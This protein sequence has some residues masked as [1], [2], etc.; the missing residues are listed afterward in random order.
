MLKINV[1]TDFREVDKLLGDLR[2]QV[3]FIASKA[4]NDTAFSVRAR[5][6][7]EL[8]ARLDKPTR[9]TLGLPRV[10][11]ATKQ[12][13]QAEVFVNDKPIGGVAPIDLLA[14]QFTGGQR[15]AKRFELLL[16]QAGYLAGN[17]VTV[18]GRGMIIDAN[19]NP[20]RSQL[21]SIL[22]ALKLAS[23]GK[24]TRKS[25]TLAGTI[26]WSQ[27]RGLPRGAWLRKGRNEIV[28]L[29]LVVK[30]ATYQQRIDFEKT[31]K[32]EIEKTWSKHFE[33]AMSYAIKTSR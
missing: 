11:K 33:S 15:R 26:I 23:P 32:D 16:R 20:K 14:Q 31:A 1:S 29:L 25:G 28:P 27:G 30:A 22:R 13:L 6:A 7:R 17:E 2:R 9:W 21:M 4:L 10:N 19:G 18:P 3:P 8:A 12:K 5:I 24:K